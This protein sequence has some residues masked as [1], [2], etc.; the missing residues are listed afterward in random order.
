MTATALVAESIPT[1]PTPTRSV[2]RLSETPGD[3]RSNFI[4]DAPNRIFQQAV[5]HREELN[6]LGVIPEDLTDLTM[7]LD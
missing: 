5:Y 2:R 6:R 3:R 7:S 1:T 4:A